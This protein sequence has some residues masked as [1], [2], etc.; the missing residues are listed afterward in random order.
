MKQTRVGVLESIITRFS[1][2]G[3]RFV[4]LRGSPGTGKTAIAKSLCEDL[5]NNQRL[6]ASFFFDKNRG[7]DGVDSTARFIS[8]LAFQLG[9]INRVYRRLL[10]G[11]LRNQPNIL[12]T[13]LTRQLQALIIEPMRK[14]C[15]GRY[16]SNTRH[17]IV[18]DGLDECRE[19][20]P[21]DDLMELVTQ[22]QQLPDHFIIFVSSRP[23]Q[24]ILHAWEDFEG[25]LHIEDLDTVNAK[26]D[27]RRYVIQHL[28]DH[29]W[30]PDKAIVSEKAPSL[31]ELE[32]FADLCGGLFL[33]A[34][35]RV[36]EVKKAPGNGETSIGA[37]RRILNDPEG[38]VEEVEKE[39]LR[40]LRHAYLRAKV[41]DDVVERYRRVMSAILSLKASLNI[42]GISQLLGEDQ[43]EVQAAL[44]LINCVVDI[45]KDGPAR[46]YHATFREFLVGNPNA[47]NYDER[48][49]HLLFVHD[50][51]G[52]LGPYCLR[53]LNSNLCLDLGTPYNPADLNTQF[54]AFY[55][56]YKE[57]MGDRLGSHIRYAAY[58]W[59][60]HVEPVI[61][62]DGVQDLFCA[63]LKEDLL[64]W[65]VLLSMFHAGGDCAECLVQCTNLLKVGH[66]TCDDWSSHNQTLQRLSDADQK[67]ALG[68]KRFLRNVADVGLISAGYL[69]ILTPRRL[70][71]TYMPFSITP[72]GNPF[73]KCLGRGVRVFSIFGEFSELRLPI[74]ESVLHSYQDFLPH[75]NRLRESSIPESA[76][77]SGDRNWLE[78]HEKVLGPSSSLEVFRP[79]I[80]ACSA[81][82]ADGNAVALAFG[83]GGI[84]ISYV[85][86]KVSSRLPFQ[87]RG[88]PI[89]MEFILAD[90]HLLLEDPTNILWLVDIVQGT[91]KQ[92]TSD[93]LSSCRSIVHAVNS[94]RD[95]IVRVPC[96]DG[97]YHWSE[98]MC[99][100]HINS[101][102]IRVRHIQPP[103]LPG[104]LHS[105]DNKAWPSRS[106]IGF[107]PNSAHVGALDESGLYIWSTETAGIVARE[108]TSSDAAWVLN[109]AFPNNSSVHDFLRPSTTTACIEC[110]GNHPSFQSP[111]TGK[112]EPTDRVDSPTPGA[113]L[114]SA[115]FIGI[116]LNTHAD[117]DVVIPRLYKEGRKPY[118]SPWWELC[119]GKY[120]IFC[121]MN[122]FMP[123]D[124]G[125]AAQSGD[126]TISDKVA[127]YWWIEKEY[128]MP[129]DYCHFVSCSD[130]GRRFL[131]K[132][133]AFAPVLVDISG[134]LSSPLDDIDYSIL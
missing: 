71:T 92:V 63:F 6:A 13:S 67:I 134:F 111:R 10:V 120:R 113:D 45:P 38:R 31:S 9:N 86:L 2:R 28:R 129:E 131:L 68:I 109:P 124:V 75:F 80:V 56:R 58:H 51:E 46:L 118:V 70:C 133:K 5:D 87:T 19:K 104:T 73:P 41:R 82:S 17:I 27:I 18:L 94:K 77:V 8:T 44:G 122:M 99:L 88:P 90:S 69:R 66:R 39:Y 103:D 115:V 84:E 79:C 74:S 4:W 50:V 36:R 126:G 42:D 7:V 60:K 24:P 97:S 93:A 35:I 96:S 12:H 40:L 125:R 64:P 49:Q 54:M 53:V 117:P 121:I 3:A 105:K 32:T 83:D 110:D 20:S 26:S 16:F 29:R 132:G 76:G 72:G 23:E 123:L 11:I 98:Q 130:D 22:L 106:S 85:D 116:N 57:T 128:R 91:R 101:P 1:G 15:E 48:E 61:S 65:V 112:E 89:W 102:D 62:L 119:H 100:I 21:L 37:F 78:A 25:P 95:V 114:E 59:A 14:A 52:F 108:M 47:L 127:E 81:L 33:I 107:S 30:N 43:L 34:E 55:S